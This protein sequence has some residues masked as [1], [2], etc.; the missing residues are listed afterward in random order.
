[1]PQHTIDAIT[2]SDG[3]PRETWVSGL[4][5]RDETQSQL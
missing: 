1:M 5:S 3:C 4:K 2:T